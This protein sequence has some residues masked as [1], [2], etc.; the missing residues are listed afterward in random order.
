[1]ISK[2]KIKTKLNNRFSIKSG[3]FGMYF[4]D[5]ITRND[6]SLNEVAELLNGSVLEDITIELDLSTNETLALYQLLV[7]NHRNT[8]H[9]L[10]VDMLEILENIRK[11]LE[12]KRMFF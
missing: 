3:K 2:M 10:S 5:N 8:I 6:L 12:L 11:Q 7:A 1:M 4:Y 9:N